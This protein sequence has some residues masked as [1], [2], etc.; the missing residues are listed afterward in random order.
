MVVRGV[1]GEYVYLA[2]PIYGRQRVLIK[3]FEES[4]QENAILAVI[5]PGAQPMKTSPLFVTPYE[6][7]LGKLNKNGDPEKGSGD[8]RLESPDARKCKV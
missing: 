7:S 5:K 3:N 1:V 2:D 6:A 8:K 4:W